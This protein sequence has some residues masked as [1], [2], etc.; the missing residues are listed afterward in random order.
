MWNDKIETAIK[1]N[2]YKYLMYAHKKG[3]KLTNRMCVSAA[4]YIYVNICIYHCHVLGTHPIYV[5]VRQNS[6]I[7]IVYNMHTRVD[8]H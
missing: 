5:I 3:T 6:G 1:Y 4:S 2:E 8:L 7:W